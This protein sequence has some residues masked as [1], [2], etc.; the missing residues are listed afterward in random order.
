MARMIDADKL[1]LHY[2]WWDN[3]GN[4]FMKDMKKTFDEV[5]DLQPTVEA[6]PVKHGYWEGDGQCSVCKEYP[7][8]R[9]MRNPNYCPNCG[10][11]MMDE[12]DNGRD[13]D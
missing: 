9:Y 13:N 1:K 8:A 6:E 7:L 12:V 4:L 5:I 2:A 3:F 10:A 11:R